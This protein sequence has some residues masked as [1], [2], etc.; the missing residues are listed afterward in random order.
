MT[1]FFR[2][3][4]VAAVLTQSHSWLCSLAARRRAFCSQKKT[5]LETRVGYE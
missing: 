4:R 2:D 1:I 3:Q 5:R